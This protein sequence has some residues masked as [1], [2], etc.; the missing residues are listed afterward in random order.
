MGYRYLRGIA[1]VFELHYTSSLQDSDRIDFP[2]AGL[3][4]TIQVA[5]NRTDMLNLT[6]GLHFQLTPS[7][8]LRVGAVA[9]L[10][11]EPDRAFDS[12]IYV[13]FNRFF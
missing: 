9:P 2:N 13:S 6:S 7:A 11:A 12:E 8:N 4:Q 5:G 1:S 3:I 10:K